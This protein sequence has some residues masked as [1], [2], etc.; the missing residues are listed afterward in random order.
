[1][2]ATAT[3]SMRIWR[4]R[5]L[6]GTW[7]SYAGFYFCRKN[8]AI[9]KGELQTIF[10]IDEFTLAHLFSAYLTAYMLGQFLTG[11]AGRK[12]AARTLLLLGMCLTLL[13]NIVFGFHTLLGPAGYWPFMIFMIING[14]A[15]STGWPGNGHLGYQ[16][17]SV[18]A[19]WFAAFMLGLLGISWSFWGASIIMFAVWIISRSFNIETEYAGYISLMFDVVGFVG[20]IFAGWVSDQYFGGHRH[21]IIL[22]MTIGMFFMLLLMVST[23]MQSVWLFT[24]FLALVGFMMMGPDPLLSGVAAIDVGGRRGAILAA[25]IINGTG[26]IGPIIQE[27]AIGWVAHHYS[28]EAS[29]YLLVGCALLG[30]AGTAYLSYRS[31]KGLSNL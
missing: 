28:F 14:F 1:M 17:G 9:L 21:Q 12:W 3:N 15:Q 19:K 10:Q 31:R 30:V 2:H 7:L 20:V 27:E 29:F 24:I 22:Y 23:G 13:C 5:V 11:I 16:V 6:T 18:L 4:V 8:Y 26:S 25:G